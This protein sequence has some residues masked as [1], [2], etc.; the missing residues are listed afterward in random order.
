MQLD[1]LYPTIT[2]K[3]KNSDGML[4]CG[5]ITYTVNTVKIENLPLGKRRA[6]NILTLPV[7]RWELSFDAKISSLLNL[8]Y[9]HLH[10]K[11]H[12]I[13]EDVWVYEL[14]EVPSYRRAT[15]LI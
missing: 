9:K 12:E 1:K 4:N 10:S 8:Q 6:V 11:I 5:P 13:F 15:P 2:E 3:E 14:Y 7:W